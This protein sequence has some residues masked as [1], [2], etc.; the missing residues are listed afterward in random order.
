MPIS[1]RKV[2][3]RNCYR[4][5]NMRTG[6]IHAKCTSKKKAKGQM[7]LLNAVDNKKTRRVKRK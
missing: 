5:K 7:R 6:K 3:N 1:V 4:V 2:K